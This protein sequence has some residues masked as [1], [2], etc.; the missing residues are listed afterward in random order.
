[1]FFCHFVAGNNFH[2]NQFVFLEDE[3]FLSEFGLSK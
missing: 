2:E 1:M 3:V